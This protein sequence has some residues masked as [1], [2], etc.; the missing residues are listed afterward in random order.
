MP[1]LRT[2]EL[3]GVILREAPGPES[4][5]FALSGAVVAITSGDDGRR[6]FR[7]P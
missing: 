6:E 1:G 3:A 7:V 5:V 2:G 4:L